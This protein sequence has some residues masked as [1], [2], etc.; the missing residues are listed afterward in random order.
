[1]LG[2][3]CCNK[4]AVNGNSSCSWSSGDTTGTLL[5]SWHCHMQGNLAKK[6]TTHAVFSCPS[7]MLTCQHQSP[8]PGVRSPKQLYA[9]LRR[10]TTVPGREQRRSCEMRHCPALSSSS[11]CTDTQ[12]GWVGGDWAA[13]LTAHWDRTSFP[14]LVGLSRLSGWRWE[15]EAQDATHRISVSHRI[16]RPSG[17]KKARLWLQHLWSCSS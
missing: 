17:P 12:T 16:K 15:A 1:M 9:K 4:K 6:G 11:V 10:Q 2:K 13:Q 8:G 3:G 14:G 5:P 7:P